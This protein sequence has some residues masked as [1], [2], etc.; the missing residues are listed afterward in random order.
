MS[1]F[2]FW[3]WEHLT[4]NILNV[5]IVSSSQLDRFSS[6]YYGG[7]KKR[8]NNTVGKTGKW[9][10]TSISSKISMKPE[11]ALTTDGVSTPFVFPTNSTMEAAQKHAH[12]NPHSQCDV[13]EVWCM[14]SDL[15]LLA[16]TGQIVSKCHFPDGG[17]KIVRRSRR[18][19]KT[20]GA[21]NQR[22]GRWK[23]KVV[24]S[25]CPK[26]AKRDAEALFIPSHY[27]GVC[28]SKHCGRQ[29]RHSLQPTGA[30]GRGPT[31]LKTLC[32]IERQVA[33]VF[34]V[35]SSASVVLKGIT[36]NV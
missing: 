31:W 15:A 34:W 5:S 10:S 28:G 33:M 35:F 14:L 21:G 7:C 11:E 32:T 1:T 25:V 6:V 2:T 19:N 12:T 23:A 20:G 13:G 27:C 36:S 26:R 30:W 22:E 8:P 18:P 3:R 4:P 17:L 29:T 16:P 9:I 24:C